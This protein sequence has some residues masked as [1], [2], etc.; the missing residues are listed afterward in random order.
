MDMLV[1]AQ[2]LYYL[3]VSLAIIVL[4]SLFA[5][6]TY[7]LIKIAKNLQDI[8]DNMEESSDDFKKR[9]EEIVERLASLPILS[10]FLK[11]DSGHEPRAS[12]KKGR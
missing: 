11:R 6:I 8:S 12:H 3:V 7:H 9:I 5:V 10:Y 4:G 1:F 2:T